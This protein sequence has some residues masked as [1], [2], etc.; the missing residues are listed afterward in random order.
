MKINYCLIIILFII[1]IYL[2]NKYYSI[3][4]IYFDNNSTTFPHKEVIKVMYDIQS[5]KDLSLGNASSTYSYLSKEILTNCRNYIKNIVPIKDAKVIFTSGGSESNNLILRGIADYNNSRKCHFITS[6]I[7]HKSIIDC[8]AELIKNN[9]IELSIIQPINGEIKPESVI[10][11]LRDNTVLVSIMHANN[12]T[13]IINDISSI[14]RAVKLISPNI[15][16]HTDAVQ[17]FSKLYIPIKYVD[18]VSVSFHKIYGPKGIGCLITNKKLCPQISGSQNY[19][20]RGGTYNIPAI[21]G[22]LTAMKYT[23]H[24]RINKNIRIMKMK[25]YILDNLIYKYPYFYHIKGRNNLHNTI[26]FSITLPNFCNKKFKKKLDAEGIAISIGSAC[27]SKEKKISHVIQAMKLPPK[28]SKGVFRI[29]IGDYN[30]ILECK[31]FVK[32]IKELLNIN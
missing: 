3:N 28:I 4:N 23:F 13:G 7:E 25:N 15:I 20:L 30:T 16:F 17:T 18:A 24:D 2:Y 14:S 9:K 19:N 5:R 8:C 11:E 31:K 29:S 12:E 6:A 22:A 10:K 32:R 21:A 27:N 26:L 1:G